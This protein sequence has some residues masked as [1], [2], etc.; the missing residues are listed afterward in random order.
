M[1]LALKRT[2]S[3]LCSLQQSKNKAESKYRD[4]SRAAP[5]DA[6]S[7]MI[8]SVKSTQFLIAVQ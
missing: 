7:P 6:K 3:W 8:G 1:L 4:G 2:A 5:I